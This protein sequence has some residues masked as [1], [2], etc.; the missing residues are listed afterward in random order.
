MAPNNTV[1]EIK[2]LVASPSDVAQ[3][4]EMAEQVIHDWHV[5]HPKSKLVLQPVLWELHGAPET[6]DRVQRGYSISRLLTSAIA[7]LVFSGHELVLKPVL[8]PEERL[9]RSRE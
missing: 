7:L 1:K 6:G 3:E 2:V 8:L 4:R 5:R 9:R